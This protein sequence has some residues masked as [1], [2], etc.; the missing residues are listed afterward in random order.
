MRGDAVT[1]L[2]G[3]VFAHTRPSDASDLVALVDPEDG[4]LVLTGANP[5]RAARRCREEQR[6]S[7]VHR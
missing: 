4:G 5:V 1:V 2:A 3:R 7:G 6:G